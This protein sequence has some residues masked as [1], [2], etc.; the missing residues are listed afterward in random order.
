[1]VLAHILLASFSRFKCPPFDLLHSVRDRAAFASFVSEILL[2]TDFNF[3]N[4]RTALGNICAA[5]IAIL[6]QVRIDH[7]FFVPGVS[8]GRGELLSRVDLGAAHR[9]RRVCDG[10]DRIRP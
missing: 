2:L 1:M 9:R 10:A 3:L 7:H 4:S 5:L 8:D 6:D